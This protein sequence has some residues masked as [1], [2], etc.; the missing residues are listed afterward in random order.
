MK[1]LVIDKQVSMSLFD[2]IRFQIN[3]Y[4]FSNNIRI[5][6]AQLDTLAHLGLWDEINIS[7]FCEQIVTEEIFGNPQTVRN[8]I[9]KS[10]KDDL[11]IRKGLGNKIIKLSDSIE[12]LNKGTVLINLKLYHVE[13][14]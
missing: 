3:F 2:I 14:S 5:S 11:I 9:I 10:I 8:F 1:A 7:D 12:L 6:P 4:C 13:E